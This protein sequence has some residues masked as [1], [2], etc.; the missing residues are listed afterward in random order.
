MERAFELCWDPEAPWP[1]CSR[2]PR[3]LREGASSLWDDPRK[4]Q[5]GG[6]LRHSFKDWK[7]LEFKAEGMIL[8]IMNDQSCH[9]PNTSWILCVGSGAKYL[10]I[11][12]RTNSAAAL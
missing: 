1:P 10:R 6:D 7:D 12:N 11:Y 3:G 8:V 4:L 9:Q 2:L 5:G